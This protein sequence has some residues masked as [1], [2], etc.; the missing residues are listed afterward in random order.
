MNASGEPYSPICIPSHEIRC[1]KKRVTERRERKN[2]EWTSFNGWGCQESVWSVGRFFRS[3]ESQLSEYLRKEGRLDVECIHCKENYFLPDIK[4]TVIAAA[5]PKRGIALTCL[6]GGGHPSTFNHY[7]STHIYLII[8]ILFN[9]YHS[10]P[11]KILNY[12]Y[13]WALFLCIHT[14]ATERSS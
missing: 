8:Y 13:L 10:I 5:R 3:V 6:S 12:I 7:D 2:W 14:Q 4:S 1:Q 9:R 11:Q